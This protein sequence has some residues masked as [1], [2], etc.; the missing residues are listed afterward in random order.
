MTKINE[1]AYTVRPGATIAEQ[2]SEDVCA[3]VVHNVEICFDFYSAGSHVFHL[4]FRNFTY[5]FGTVCAS[6]SLFFSRGKVV[7]YV[8][9]IAAFSGT[10][11][12]TKNEC[13]IS[14]E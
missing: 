14:V 3:T 12:M 13:G 9:E 5:S 11:S 10:I 8:C 7:I 1:P 6:D 2:E 4:Q